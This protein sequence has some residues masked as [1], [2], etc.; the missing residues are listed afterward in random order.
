MVSKRPFFLAF[1]FLFW[2][3]RVFLLHKILEVKI[4][5]KFAS[6]KGPFW[7]HNQ[8]LE[9]ARIAKICK[10][11]QLYRISPLVQERRSWLASGDEWRVPSF[12]LVSSE[13]EIP[14]GLSP[15]LHELDLDLGGLGSGLPTAT[16]TK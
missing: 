1:L 11:W 15:A 5:K 3:F 9:F 4:C 16:W 8:T 12:P 6:C 2:S 14:C 10:V 13:G 7:S